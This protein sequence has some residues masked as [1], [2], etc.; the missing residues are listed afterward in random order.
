MLWHKK[1]KVFTKA[2]LKSEEKKHCSDPTRKLKQNEDWRLHMHCRDLCSPAIQL[3][4]H[5]QV[6]PALRSPQAIPWWNK[7]QILKNIRDLTKETNYL[8]KLTFFLFFFNYMNE[9]QTCL[10]V[11]PKQAATI[12]KDNVGK[13][14]R[15]QKDR[16]MWSASNKREKIT[17]L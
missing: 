13:N 2:V 17:V 8:I 1:K 12:T 10:N 7:A 4:W 15:G 3:L 6:L 5:L 11:L 16:Y 14:Q 9:G